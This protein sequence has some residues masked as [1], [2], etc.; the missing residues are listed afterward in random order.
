MFEKFIKTIRSRYFYLGVM[1]VLI[2]AAMVLRLINLQLINGHV[3]DQLARSG[4]TGTRM[5]EAPRGRIFDRNGILIAYNRTGFNVKIV[6]SS[7]SRNQ[8]RMDEIYYSLIKMLEANGDSP[9]NLLERFLTEDIEFGAVTNHEHVEDEERRGEIIEFRENWV[10]RTAYRLRGL[11]VSERTVR[12]LT[13]ARETFEFLRET[14]FRIC[15]T[16]EERY[17]YLIMAIRYTILMRGGALTPTPQQIA[18][19]ISENSMIEIENRHL[20]FPGIYTE[21]VYFRQY[22]D[23]QVVSHI[24]GYVRPI[25]EEDW[26]ETFREL[27]G[28]LQTDIVGKRGIESAAEEYLRGIRGSRTVYISNA[29]REI[30]EID[31]QEPLPGK[32]IHLTIDLNLQREA[33]EALIRQLEWIREQP[34]GYPDQTNFGDAQAGSVVVMDPNTGEILAMASYPDY[35]P[36]IFLAPSTDMEAQ[37]AITDLYRQDNVLSPGLNRATWGLYA[38]GSSFKPITALAGLRTGSI[39]AH[40]PIPCPGQWEE[41]D[42]TLRCMSTHG[43]IGLRRAM[44][45][46]CNVYFFVG[47]VRTGIDN[48][49]ETARWFGL[50]EST[51]IEISEAPDNDYPVRGRSMRSNPGTMN[52][53]EIDLTR[54][55]GRADTAQSSIGQLY[56]RFTPLQLV[57]YAGALGTNGNLVQPHIIRKIVCPTGEVTPT[58]RQVSRIEGIDNAHYEVITGSLVEAVE[59]LQTSQ[60]L[61]ERRFRQFDFDV[62]GKTGTSQHGLRDRSS[63]GVFVA[64]APARNPEISVSVVVEHGVWGSFVSPIASDVIAQFFGY[65]DEDDEPSEAHDLRPGINP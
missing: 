29:G 14:V 60:I 36:N 63:H 65:N 20:E 49:D 16:F 18:T 17:A 27:D 32:D 64:Y 1:V 23:P 56:T 50:G 9:D 5:I 22:N 58:I 33:R 45:Q 2:V 25:T 47:G 59:D 34:E 54:I 24:L 46:S 51:G 28:Y 61:G 26:E 30:R 52:R 35:D 53:E 42:V 12:E 6:S 62:A 19:D 40:A 41:G 57:R 44:R 39:N 10:V 21:Q 15:D 7:E 55:W 13:T 37:K 4:V 43:D 11:T 48:I 31:R 8:E 38:P 3:F